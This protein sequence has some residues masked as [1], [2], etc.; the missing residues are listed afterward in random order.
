MARVQLFFLGTPQIEVDGTAVATD[1][2]KAVALL[3]YLA[4]TGTSHSRE[5][6]AA[7]FW[8]E[9]DQTRA[10][11]YLRRTLWEINQMLGEGWLEAERSSV[12]LRWP[13]EMWLDV[14]EFTR[15]TAIG[16]GLDDLAT[17]VFLYRDDFLAGFT[18][19]DAPDFDE[20][21]YYEVDH[22]RHALAQAL[23]QLVTGLAQVGEWETAVAHARRWLALD[24]L[25]EL[26]HRQL[27]ELYA[28][29]GNKAAAL[30]QYETCARILADELD[31]IPE[32][33]T[34][35][36]YDRI[37]R[38]DFSPA[39]KESVHVEIPLPPVSPPP[40]M[41]HNLPAA[42]TPFIGRAPELAEVTRMLLDPAL[43]LLSLVGPGG[44]GKTRLALQAAAQLSAAPP[45]IFAD[46]V[47]F[48]P[49]AA[50]NSPENIIPAIAKALRLSFF[51]EGELPRQQLFD[52]LRSR[53][54]LLLLDNYEHLLA[55]GSGAA[56]VSEL[57]TVAPQ[58]KIMTTS[59]VR[60]GLQAEHLY[61]VQG[62]RVPDWQT[63]VSW[64][65]TSQPL[66]DLITPYS[67]VQLFVAAAQRAQ[68]AFTLTPA[69]LLPVVR[70]CRLLDGMPLAL[71]LA[72]AW[73]S[74]L[75]LAEIETEIRQNLDFLATE[76]H[77]V[78]E[79][80]RSI[81]AVFNYSWTL[82]TEAE[83]EVLPQL[84]IFQGGFTRE[85]AQHVAGTSLPILMALMHKSL[86]RREENGRFTM[87]E[88]LRQYAAERLHDDPELWVRARDRHSHFYMDMLLREGR[89]MQSTAQ[90]AG[91]DV[92]ELEI[93]NMR[94]AWLWAMVQQQYEMV[95]PT[96]NPLLY[97]YLVRAT[98]TELGDLL[99]MVLE[100][101]ETAVPTPPPVPQ[102][103]DAA[104]LLY[105]R[106][107]A[108]QSWVVS[109]N[110]T[111]LQ[112]V[113]F[114]TK[115]LEIIDSW[116]IAAQIGLPLTL[117][118]VIYAYRVDGA[119]GLEMGWRSLAYL[120]QQGDRWAVALAINML[121]ACLHSLGERH[122]VKELLHEG[123]AISREIGDYLVL[124]YNL[125]TLAWVLTDER[126][127]QQALQIDQECQALFEEVGD[128]A[129]A[130]NNLWSLAS[131][132]DVS[133][134]YA[135]AVQHYQRSHRL[136]LELGRR[137]EVA[138]CLGW[139]SQMWQRLGEYEK[140]LVLRQQALAL[141]QEMGDDNGEAW[142][143]FE[144][145]ELCRLLDRPEAESF[146]EQAFAA[147]TRLQMDHGLTF[148]YRVRGRARLA[149][150][151]VVGARADLEQSMALSHDNS[152]DYWNRA[153]TLCELA[154]VA[155]TEKD[156]ETAA[157]YFH[158]AL[159]L[160]DRWA[161]LGIILVILA[162]MAHMW[163]YQ[164]K[165][166]QA[167][168]M[169]ALVLHH[170]AVWDETRPLA[171]LPLATAQAHM[172]EAAF[173][174]AVSRGQALDLTQVVRDLLAA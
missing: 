130:A 147:F 137:P 63:A 105:A 4:V 81:R 114:S 119:E 134:E 28:H 110:Y 7:L 89:R 138:N 53:S 57:L 107:L 158:D 164:K 78:P 153:Y 98:L 24:A 3:A 154:H 121:G 160:A 85:A 125:T 61:M 9:A 14:R 132:Y 74:L 97:F 135:L 90:R 12:A 139:E 65:T 6:L 104:H 8:P 44:S 46:G 84:T 122:G 157:S 144:V 129:G 20:W 100:D 173:A 73:L 27:M 103:P 155:L 17:A 23:A 168:E 22:L 1:R 145:G 152:E 19:R 91:F 25:H 42:T 118:A 159:Q 80:Q 149:A 69:T 16:A 86:I 59:R 148:Y 113:T 35:A 13:A 112:P 111:A 94:A 52:Y 141:Y 102:Q 71:E 82:L 31:A 163:A 136:Y 92:V 41:R 26:A 95:L 37:R 151:D 2:R 123:V 55:N 171:R 47:Y 140:A 131:V 62:M 115:A 60:L 40:A 128:R 77:D 49:L 10:F 93:E 15:L 127:F 166:V 29:M 162:G 88:L 67:S 79:R 64:Q 133:G 51:K 172:D 124:A 36:L 117:A 161:S 156:Y 58:V 66:T 108:L 126:A 11:A 167:A 101:L 72:A 169:A 83:K 43:R 54:L 5:T 170:R 146:Y 99:A 45:L 150:G 75:T 96:L 142:S 56:Q 87:H 106:L 116:G 165:Y 174:T 18:L 50:L 30:R 68:P 32:A 48:V 70:I 39:A 34:T 76:M 143:Y 33:A 21:Q 38:G 109:S 120:R